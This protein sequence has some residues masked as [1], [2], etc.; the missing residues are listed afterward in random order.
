MTRGHCGGGVKARCFAMGRL[1]CVEARRTKHRRARA[2]TARK[3]AHRAQVCRLGA[4]PGRTA[5]AAGLVGGAARLVVR[6]GGRRRVG[7]QGHAARPEAHVVARKGLQ[8]VLF[9][10][11]QRLGKRQAD[12]SAHPLARAQRQ[13]PGAALGLGCHDVLVDGCTAGAGGAGVCA[14]RGHGDCARS[15]SRDSAARRRWCKAATSCP[16]HG[17]H[18]RRAG[19][20]TPPACGAHP[21]THW[22]S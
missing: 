10:G 11:R 8:R 2:P 17:C 1:G 5:D 4:G 19:S 15:H 13:D 20:G 9:A 12:A 14:A 7:V 6:A 21:Q 16:T 18:R 22:Q 3:P